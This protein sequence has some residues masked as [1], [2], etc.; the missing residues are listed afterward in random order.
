MPYRRW[1][2]SILNWFELVLTIWSVGA[3]QKPHD[4]GGSKGFVFILWGL[5]KEKKFR[6]FGN[7]LSQIVCESHHG[8]TL[9]YLEDDDIH[10]VKAIKKTVAFHLYYPK[11]KRNNFYEDSS[12]G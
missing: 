8:T 7:K 12:F 10:D 6:L 9:Y 5:L 11:P 4:H 2:F 1:S 3:Y